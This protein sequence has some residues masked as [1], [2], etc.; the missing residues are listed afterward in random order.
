MKDK[1]REFFRKLLMA[2]AVV[3]IAFS[4]FQLFEIYKE[5]QKDVDVGKE[6]VEIIGKDEE[7]DSIQFLTHES[8]AKLN[9]INEDLIGY[10]YYPSLDIN[11]VVTQSND[12]AYYLTRSFYKEYMDYGTVFMSY[13][14]TKDSQNKTLYGHWIQNSTAK[15]SNLHKLQDQ[16]NYE[17]NKTFFFADDEFVREYEVAYVIYHETYDDDKNV[18]YWQGDFSESQFNEFIANSQ[19][20][21]MY[22]AGVEVTYDDKLI[23]L[24]TCITYDSEERLV[25]IGKEINKVPLADK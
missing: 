8:F 13:D 11:E 21:Q 23:S 19:H 18:P 5:K 17:S 9:A 12:N 6:I 25:V 22:D 24:Q 15:F 4:S 3:A 1:V 16:A 10:L 20:Q 7:D 2:V 14:Q